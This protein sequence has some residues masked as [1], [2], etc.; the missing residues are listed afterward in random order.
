MLTIR[1][2]KTG[3]NAG[4]GV[5]AEPEAPQPR[6]WRYAVAAPEQGQCADG[7]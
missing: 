6:A 7:D 5:A 4:G 3:S 1:E 2:Y